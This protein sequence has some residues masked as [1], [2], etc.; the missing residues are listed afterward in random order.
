M[1]RLHL[2]IDHA[3]SVTYRRVA[4]GR[5]K[6]VAHISLVRGIPFYGY[7]V[8]YSYFL[9]IYLLNPLHK[10]RL[11]DLLLSGTIMSQVFQ[12]YENHLQYLLQWMCD[13]NLFGCAYIESSD[14]RFR[15][16]VPSREILNSTQHLWHEDSIPLS[17]VLD[18]TEFPKQSY[19]SVEVDINVEHILNRK[20]IRPR[21]RHHQFNEGLEP[22]LVSERL[23]PSME[24]LWK[25]EEKRRLRS[26]AAHRPGHS[27]FPPEALLSMS[28]EPRHPGPDGW[29]NEAEYRALLDQIIETEKRHREAPIKPDEVFDSF[30]S[31][32]N[33]STALQSVEDLYGGLSL[34]SDAS[35]SFVFGD[36]GV[37]ATDIQV[38][39]KKILSGK[40]VGQSPEG[41]VVADLSGE[42][43]ESD[44]DFLLDQSEE[45]I[46]K[47]E[48]LVDGPNNKSLSDSTQPD[49]IGAFGVD[50][51]QDG[52]ADFEIPVEFTS[53]PPRKRE[54]RLSKDEIELAPSKKPKIATDDPI[55][56]GS[57]S[58]YRFADGFGDVLP[59][60]SSFKAPVR[61]SQA[62]EANTKMGFAMD[63]GAQS[64]EDVPKKIQTYNITSPTRSRVKASSKK[65]I[66]STSSLSSKSI[67]QRL[68]SRHSASS[69]SRKVSGLGQQAAQ[70]TDS[71]RNLSSITNNST[72]S[73]VPAQWASEEVNTRLKHATSIAFKV[74]ARGSSKY[75][76]LTTPKSDEVVSNL[77]EIGFD[78][79]IY[80]GAYYSSD[81]DVPERPREYAGKEFRLRS[82]TVPFLPDF[83]PADGSLQQSSA[84]RKVERVLA[85][86][87]AGLRRMRCTLRSWEYSIRPPSF[88]DVKKWLENH[89]SDDT[90]LKSDTTKQANIF[91]DNKRSSQIE[92][93][94]Q[95]ADSFASEKHT[96][97][98]HET[99]YMSLMSLE[100]HVNTRGKLLP[101][102]EFDE[103]Q[104]I[105]WCVQS[106][107][108]LDQLHEGGNIRSGIVMQAREDQPA[109]KAR[110]LAKL[111]VEEVDNELDLIMRMIDIVRLYDPDILTGF[112]VHNASWG[113]IIERS[114]LKY[115][116]NIC[117]EFSRTRSQSHG[118][119]GKDNDQWGFNHTSTIRITGRHMINVWRAMRSELA[120]LQYTMEN[121]VFHLLH[122]RIPHY[123][124][125][126][127][128]KWY[129]SDIPRDFAT[130]ITYYASR[131]LLDLEI[132]EK[133]EFVPRTSEQA[134]LLGVDFFSVISRGSQFKVESLMFRIAKPENYILISPSKKQVGGQNALECLPLVMEPQ[135]AFYSGPVLVLDFQSL[136]PSI[137][138]AYNY[139]YSTFVGRVETWRGRNKMGFTEY[140]RL[141]RLLELLGDMYN[142]APNGMVYVKP[143]VRRSL[144]ARMLSEILETRFMCK[145]GMKHDL[146][147]K[148]LQLLLHHRQLALKLMANV[149]YGYT[150]ASFSGRM[151][152][153]EI[154]DS[155][156]QTARETLEKTIALIHSVTAWGAEVVYGDTDSIFV[157]LKG[158]TKDEAFAI[159][160]EIAKTVTEA[161]PKPIKL[162]FEKVYLPS[163][164]LAK[165]RYVGFK[166]ESKD[167]LD[168][169]IDA[170]GIEVIRRDGTPAEQKIEEACL[171]ILFRTS[172]LS[173]IKTYFQQQCAKVM[174]G[175]VSI[176]DF[177]FA[178]EVRLGSYSENGL[179]PPGALI[180]TRKMMEDPRAEPQY[181]ERVPYVVITGAPGARLIDRCVSPEMMLQNPDWELDSEYYI[182][183]NL[184]PPLE[185]IFNL[186]GVNVL[187]WYDEIP[188]YQRARRIEHAKADAI[189][190][191]RTLESYMKGS[192][193][194][195]CKEPTESEHGLC[196]DCI[197]D[198]QQSIL[199][200]QGKL[201]NS[202]KRLANIES[203][204]RSCSG[205]S[206][207]CEV[208]CDS[209]DCE[210]FWSREKE[211]SNLAGSTA[212]MKP[213][214]DV[215]QSADSTLDW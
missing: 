112:E 39:V 86:S 100:V 1:R 137:M 180:S 104:A 62:P 69:S 85:G 6:F 102:P 129:Q 68:S 10:T 108:E 15:G 74:K 84:E 53:E 157:H 29:I 182:L 67:S 149:T 133:Q 101:N 92:T 37:K 178:K 156:V 50:N 114:R 71:S 140:N 44:F 203:V 172:D 125:R 194:L 93:V 167:Q 11:G 33:V 76:D 155:I 212:M 161:N 17:H 14:V 34:T 186:M 169:V 59:L 175:R 80:H 128:T 111:E 173:Q 166:Y 142:I 122:R 148:T 127:L 121:V 82:N 40:V 90:K 42:E 144:L 123:S 185:R 158:R 57:K 24:G 204:C 63:N 147:D 91:S 9:K 38:D 190:L 154:A 163:V 164:L 160:N 146:D 46:P 120:L 200:L 105:F 89:A 107:E 2:S 7:H 96:S 70:P 209:K 23:V 78:S 118:R 116:L 151:P 150:S 60:Q 12:P 66:V 48:D 16:P 188:K 21:G 195:V 27:P 18:S 20:S 126:D 171:N 41:Q 213:A 51:M 192:V 65:D 43:A 72:T 55:P 94:A 19:C 183:K 174:K 30:S 61:I 199:I 103:I 135:S 210:V 95:K 184:I 31:L 36:S 26:Q 214:L 143:E 138:I 87:N 208:K 176:Q 162:K 119:F 124:Y 45:Q 3:L 159:G 131:T 54:S 181:G 139:C 189:G 197:Q 136:Y 205:T 77:L 97:V 170:K 113:Y 75:I 196:P 5:D 8:G 165:K 211:K 47:A 98:K 106:D 193:C 99:Q 168:G 134:R 35:L 4:G 152:C 32:E 25:S 13:Y 201:R 88:E 215:L 115:E 202:E 83:C 132:L 130:C 81:K 49:D 73:P 52:E 177:C 179:P 145:N 191:K 56:S 79:K 64:E 206:F 58:K 207:G 109:E 153:S 110:K 117:D 141:P 187:S 28:A 198:R 22:H